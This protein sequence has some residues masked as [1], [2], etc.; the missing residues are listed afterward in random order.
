VICETGAVTFETCGEIDVTPDR[1]NERRFGAW[2][3]LQSVVVSG[4]TD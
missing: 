3:R 4:F 1:T 2:H